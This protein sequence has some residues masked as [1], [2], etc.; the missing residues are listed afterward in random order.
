[1]IADWFKIFLVTVIPGGVYGW[2]F[3]NLPLTR[4]LM[5]CIAN[6]EVVPLLLAV[7]LSQASFQL[8]GGRADEMELVLLIH[9]AFFPPIFLSILL[10]YCLSHFHSKRRS[11]E[12]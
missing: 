1:M 5:W 6:A 9:A 4:G 3:R 8:T 10:G 2:T 7:Y 12:S 11:T